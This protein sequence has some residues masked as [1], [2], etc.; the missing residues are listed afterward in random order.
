[1][2]SSKVDRTKNVTDE[3]LKQIFDNLDKIE[4]LFLR[5]A[6]MFLGTGAIYS[7][8]LYLSAIINRAISFIRGFKLLATE[9]N[10]ISSVP[11]IRMQIDNCLRLYA[12][13]L[14]ESHNDFFLAYLDGIH[15]RNMKDANGNKMTDS[16]LIKQLDKIFPGIHNLYNNTSGYVHLSNEHAFLQTEILKDDERKMG[17]RIGYYDFYAIDEKVDFAYNMFKASQFLLELVTSWRL[18]KLKS[19]SSPKK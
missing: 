19:N 11:I 4:K 13:T 3:D 18:Q 9:N 1:M 16:Y 2:S 6:K 8:D 5:E 15:I 12:G 17:T 7:T 14:V 10:Y